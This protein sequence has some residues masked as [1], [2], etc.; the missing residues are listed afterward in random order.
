MDKTKK[1]L[2]AIDTWIGELDQ[3]ALII[4]KKWTPLFY[5]DRGLGLDAD[6]ELAKAGGLREARQRVI[7]LKEQVKEALK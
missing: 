7:K 1:A 3:E 5:G 6:R 2:E 4:E